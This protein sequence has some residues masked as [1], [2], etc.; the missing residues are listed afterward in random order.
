MQSFTVFDI[1]IVS[2]TLLLGLKGLLRGFI[3][4]IFGLIGIIGGIFVASRMAAEIGNAIAPV[5]ALENNA[6]I[7]LIGFILGLIL[8]WAIIYV[9]GII[10]SKIFSASG[11][12]F[13]DRI[14]GFL[15]GSA[16]IFFI[17]S[18]IAYALF[19]VQSFKDL[20]NNKISDS[21]TFPLLVQTGSFIVK[22]D[23]SDF[24]KKVE[25]SV[26]KDE[27]IVEDPDL[28]EKKSITQEL[29]DTVKEIKEK[30]VESG[31]AVVDSVKKSVDKKVDEIADSVKND[32][33]K[34]ITEN[35]TEENTTT[36]E[37]K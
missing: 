5:L 26:T 21:I 9:L 14:L 32:V 28:I 11:L 22:L 30:T 1:V 24:V 17:F 16:K 33:K 8:F 25:D 13:F 37:N 15:F 10:L 29:T 7:K 35:T 34:E 12:G 31:S 36:E 27:D 6:T 3:K 18:I 2:I 19:Q 20:M 4:E 23:A